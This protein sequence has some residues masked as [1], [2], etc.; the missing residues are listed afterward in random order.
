MPNS[1]LTRTTTA[2]T[3]G[4]VL[5]K[6]GPTVTRTQVTLGRTGALTTEIIKGLP[7]GAEVVLANL[8]ADLPSSST[9]ST[10]NV[11]GLSG[12]GGSGGAPGGGGGATGGGGGAPPN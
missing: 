3:T 11:G 1:A 4:S 5:V 10:R 6:T 12:G 9:T 7:V 2:G 8:A